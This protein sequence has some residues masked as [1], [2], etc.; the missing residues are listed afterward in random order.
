M[1]DIYADGI[2]NV[3]L[4][5][6]NARIDLLVVGD[7]PDKDGNPTMQKKA[8]LI[9]PLQGLIRANIQIQNVLDQLTEKGVLKKKDVNDKTTNTQ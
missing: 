8:E 1:T 9:I 6:T 3:R 5:G 7:Q 2:G 4:A